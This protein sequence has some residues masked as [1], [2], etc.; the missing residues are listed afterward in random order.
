MVQ[1]RA[2]RSQKLTAIY[3]YLVMGLGVA[4]LVFVGFPTE[5]GSGVLLFAALT[6]AA[7]MLPVSVP[8]R[9]VTIS[10]GLATHLPMVMLFGPQAAVWTAAIATV[11]LK[12]LKGKVSLEKVI[13]NRAQLAISVGLASFVYMGLGGKVGD[14]ALGEQIVP[15]LGAAL[16]CLLTNMTAISL[17]LSLSLQRPFLQTWTPHARYVIPQWIALTFLGVLF[18]IV[19]STAGGIGVILFAVPL[20]LA[21]YSFQQYADLREVFLTTINAL[22]SAIDAKDPYTRGH[23]A[24]TLK[25]AVAIAREL[26]W[27]DDLIE[28]L[29]YAC[30]LHDLGKIGIPD[31]IL[32]KGENLTAEEYEIQKRH[33]QIGADIIKPIKFLNRDIGWIRHHHEWF[34]GRGYPDG[35]EGEEIPIGA[36]VIAVADAFDA[37]TSVRP[38]RP[39]M[40]PEEALAELK[41]KAGTQFDPVIVEAFERAVLHSCPAKE[42]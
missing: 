18:A 20:G 32:K 7:E 5:I 23:S 15:A 19:Y 28:R 29:Q 41:N 24:Q 22:V 6:F 36:R 31:S 33:P 25:H 3:V 12:E 8:G 39:A 38:Y 4:L 14:I 17:V 1:A 42:A 26:R 35:L 40:K 16:T 9:P 2:R 30:L 37:M 13:F 10:V 11:R 34:D 21:R 27:G